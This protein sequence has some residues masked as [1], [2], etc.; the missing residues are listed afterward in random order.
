[1]FD[2]RLRPVWWALRITFG[3]VP[4]LA[5]L[6]KFFE[7]LAPWHQYLSPLV[8]RV[9]P[10]SAHAFMM[11]VGVIEIIAGAIVLSPWVRLGST[12][13][14]FWLVAIALNLLTTGHYLDIAVRDL[15]M[16]VAAFSL[17]RL[18]SVRQESD[19]RAPLRELRPADASI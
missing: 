3:V 5:G 9:L 16:A 7:L 19:E 6:D 2:E 14:G 15:V 10:I 1:M 13:V 11:A 4:I 12:I 17:A 8:T 18:E